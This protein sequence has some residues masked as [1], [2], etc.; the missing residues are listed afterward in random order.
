MHTQ[1]EVPK[2]MFDDS[3]LSVVRDGEDNVVQVKDAKKML[4]GRL[5]GLTRQGEDYL[6]AHSLVEGQPTTG[7]AD[8]TL[9]IERDDDETDELEDG[10]HD[11]EAEKAT[12][13]HAYGSQITAKSIMHPWAIFTANGKD[14]TRAGADINNIGWISRVRVPTVCKACGKIFSGEPCC[15]KPDMRYTDVFTSTPK[16]DKR[17]EYPAEAYLNNRWALFTVEGRDYTRDDFQEK[18]IKTSRVSQVMAPVACASCGKSFSVRLVKEKDGEKAGE[19]AVPQK[20]CDNFQISYASIL[21]DVKPEAKKAK[22]RKT[23]A[24]TETG[25][26]LHETVETPVFILPPN[27]TPDVA[28]IKKAF[29]YFFTGTVVEVR[30]PDTSQRVCSGYYDDFEIA[31]NDAEKLS[32]REDTCAVYMTIQKINPALLARRK[33]RVKPWAKTTTGEKDVESYQYLV[34]DFDPKRPTVISSSDV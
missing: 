24:A 15:A 13:V 12:E 8:D 5:Q 26:M 9:I 21:Y 23:K 30:A 32:L 22:A 1:N 7:I 25:P 28:E 3:A 16:R 33:N 18:K 4:W 31:A 6:A 2:Q 19:K 27:P 10:G 29:D 20:C 17:A 11:D 34:L 14:Y